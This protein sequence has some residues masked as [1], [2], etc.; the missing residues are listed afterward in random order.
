MDIRIKGEMDGIE[1]AEVIRN[2]FGIPVIFSTAYLDQE[3]IERAK[4]TMP[5]G[6]VLKPIQDRDLKVTLEMAF[7]VAKV[8]AK[9]RK[10]EGDLKESEN[11]LKQA[12]KL[13]KIGHR[14]WFMDTG[15]L[16]WSDEVY[17]IFGQDKETFKVTAESFENKIHSDDFDA[18]VAERENAL[19][20]KRDVNIEHRIIL[21]WPKYYFRPESSSYL[22]LMPRSSNIST[23]VL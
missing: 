1:T 6:Y 22:P 21:V 16:T 12:Q 3:R 13:A 15:E 17:D 11:R 20:E 19:A 7:Y 14:D 9:R 18:F 8:D 4:I 10:A 2:K 5:F 23:C